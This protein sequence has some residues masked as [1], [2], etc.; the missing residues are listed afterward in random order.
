M[1]FLEEPLKQRIK[2]TLK[3]LQIIFYLATLFLW[4]KGNFLAFKKIRISYLIPLLILLILTAIRL[5]LKSSKKKIRFSF[6]INKV[7]IALLILVTIATLVR[8]PFL[9]NNFGLMDG[10]EAIPALAGK[11]ISEGKVPALFYYGAMFQGSLPQHFYALM[12]KLFGYS[13]LVVK[14]TA[15]IAFVFFL[16]I[17]FI[18]LNKIFS[19]KFALAICSFYCFPF[20]NLIR[21]SFDIGSGFPFVLLMGILIFYLTYL[22]Y[23]NNQEK[24]LPILGF[25]IGLTLWTHQITVSIILTSFLFILLKFK[26]QWK[27]YLTLIFYAF[28]GSFPLILNEVYYKFPLLRFLFSYGTGTENPNKL[29]TTRD[30]T[31]SLISHETNFL[32]HL[33]LILIFLGAFVLLYLSLKKK[34]F[35]PANLYLIFAVLFFLIYIFSGFS[36]IVVSRYLYPFYIVLPVLLSSV[37]YLLK[38]KIKYIIPAALFLIMFFVSEAKTTNSFFLSTKEEHIQLRNIVSAMKE[39]HHKYWMGNYWTAYL[40]TSLTGENLTVAS[41]TITRYLPYQLLYYNE[42]QDSNWVF[43]GDAQKGTARKLANA[44]G[45][46]GI[47]AKIKKFEKGRLIYDI[48]G[49][50]YP[51]LFVMQNLPEKVPEFAL[52]RIEESKGYLELFFKTKEISSFGF[53]IHAE[54]EKF[55]TAVKTIAVDGEETKVKIPFPKKKFFTVKY[56]LE[57]KGMI[58]R[59]TFCEFSYNLSPQALRGKRKKFIYLSGFGPRIN[60][61]NE[62]SIFCGKKIRIE[63]NKKMKKNQK[64]YIY[65]FSHF[66]FKD[67]SWYGNYVQKV[68]FFI[69]KQLLGE[70]ELLD[71]ENILTIDFK[72]VRKKKKSNI[73]ELQFKYCLPLTS[74]DLWRTS[75]LLELEKIEIK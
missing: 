31:L 22:I 72:K 48:D 21:T 52:E 55:S 18:L 51:S 64:I 5:C 23:Y 12:F 74:Y 73:L 25:L 6:K 19:F 30:V 3:Y 71:G 1:E 41:Y 32:N 46:L 65:L 39:T 16:A 7:A 70:K 40:I 10:D 63:I 50:F 26:L 69:N 53:R 56:Y 33:Y 34:K 4:F 44:I 20:A 62:K 66:D 57:F 45:N 54:I 47:K 36:N 38:S 15:F 60:F 17:Q 13:I 24:C 75:A 68:S 28:I 58:I 2:K 59:S 11:H 49:D 61:P 27:K 42:S 67:L 43:F 9:I 14:I 35:L 37:F 29:Q 8:I